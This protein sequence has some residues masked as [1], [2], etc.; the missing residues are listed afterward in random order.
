MG[1]VQG[2][3]VLEAP[4]WSHS[5]LLDELVLSYALPGRAA[6]CL[7]LGPGWPRTWTVTW[8]A[9]TSERAGQRHR[10]GLECLVSTGRQHGFESLAE[11]WLLLVL[12]FVGGFDEVLS[13]PFRLRFFSSEGKGSHIRTSS[14]S[15]R[16]PAG[17][18]TCGQGIWSRRRT[19]SGSPRP[20]R[21]R[22]PRAG[23]ISW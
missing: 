4:V 18:W 22:Q 8:K 16:G 20:R 7:D 12:D 23:A 6:E 11:R 17:W 9:G 15:L 14:C 2:I 1:D 21:W 5:C 10:P 13:Q 3:D 19:R